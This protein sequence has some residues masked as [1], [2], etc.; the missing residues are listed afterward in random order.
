M[1]R[2]AH[3]SPALADTARQFGEHARQYAVS[4]AHTEGATRL[5]LLERMEPVADERLLDIGSGPGPVAIAFAPY[6]A[7]AI[8]Y[9][10][11]P[12][13][14]AA[15]RLASRRAGADSVTLVCGDAHRLPFSDH[16]F[17]LVTSR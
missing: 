17:G 11:A 6:V 1:P 4:R 10:A 8:A 15:A 14:L 3:G 13:M 12:E 2:F 7:G 16:A 5:M 9:D